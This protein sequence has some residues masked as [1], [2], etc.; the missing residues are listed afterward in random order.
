M[1]LLCQAK[2]KTDDVRFLDREGGKDAVRRCSLPVGEFVT[3]GEVFSPRDKSKPFPFR[4]IEKC[5]FALMQ[6]AAD[7]CQ[8]SLLAYLVEGPGGVAVYHIGKHRSVSQGEKGCL[9]CIVGFQF[10]A[11]TA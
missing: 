7:K 1:R 10:A 11:F 5:L 3:Y 9:E 6:E 8:A 2:Q 4:L